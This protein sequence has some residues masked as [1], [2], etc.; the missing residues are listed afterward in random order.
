MT[1]TGNTLG[2]GRIAVIV[3][4]TDA[5][6][7]I[8]A[9]LT[10]F[11]EEV[12]GRGE[13][14]VVDAS[15]DGTAEEIARAFAGVR[16]L[17]RPAGTLAPELWRDGML[18]TDAPLVALST[19]RMVPVHGWLE[20]MLERLETTDAAVAGGPIEPASGLA[21]IDRAVYLHR[22]VNYLRPLPAIRQPDPP[23]DN[24]VYRRERLKGL[25]PLWSRG[26]WE[27]EV[28]REL[29]RTGERI[30]MADR[31][32]VTYLGGEHLARCLRQRYRH[33]HHFGAHRARS[34]SVAERLARTIAAP[35]VPLVMLGRIVAALSARG[36][37]LVPWIA[38]LPE[39][40]PLLGAWACG[41]VL[42]TWSASS[43]RSRFVAGSDDGAGG[44]HAGTV[45]PTKLK[46]TH[47]HAK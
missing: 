15:C 43:A 6:A 3:A 19:A 1:M 12:G 26:I 13:V 8:R 40:V 44:G 31:A 45:K 47:H 18:A 28:H 37:R 2:T 30:V 42:G 7:T 34:L 29:R 20:A 23:G 35:L 5:V 17:R 33:G 27:V 21:P 14:I 39:L 16:V 41:E 24:T 36:Q 4:S 46:F 10:R 25:E 38:A 11:V 9:C 22:Y 32:S